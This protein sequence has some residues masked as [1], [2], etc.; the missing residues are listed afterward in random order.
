MR[1]KETLLCQQSPCSQSYGFSSSHVRMWELD[2]KESWAPKNGC[3]WTMVLEKTLQSPLDFKEIQPVHSEGDQAWDFFGRNDV[4]AE[5]AI[6]WHLMRRTDSFEKTLNLREIEAR[7]RRGW[8]RIRW[9]DGI[10]DSMDMSLINS[11]SWWWTG[12]PDVL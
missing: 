9:L 6:L 8:Q 1:D 2:S 3:F 10:T 7:C 5:T 11:R 12:R 4:K